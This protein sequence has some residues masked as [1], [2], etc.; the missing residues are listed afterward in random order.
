MGVLTL[1][2][3]Y[4]I[5]KI[6][7]LDG[8]VS[9]GVNHTFKVVFTPLEYGEFRLYLLFPPTSSIFVCTLQKYSLYVDLQ[10]TFKT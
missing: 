8:V 6:P 9:I 10:L 5:H 4:Q 3:A 7:R 2:P 1:H